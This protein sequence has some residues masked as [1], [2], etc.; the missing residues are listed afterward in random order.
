MFFLA[1]GRG[2]ESHQVTH[3][4]L[5]LVTFYQGFHAFVCVCVCV[6]VCVHV[7]VCTCVCL[8]ACAACLALSDC[9]SL[10][11]M[12]YVLLFLENITPPIQVVDMIRVCG[13]VYGIHYTC[14]T[15]AV[16]MN[17]ILDNIA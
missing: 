8:S 1:P 13:I 10:S 6:C 7:C 4:T 17:I 2:F 14:F 11:T 16:M 3:R 9:L 12:S 15:G 5:S